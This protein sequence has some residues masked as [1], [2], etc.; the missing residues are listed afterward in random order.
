METKVF[1]SAA[2]DDPAGRACAQVDAREL[3]AAYVLLRDADE[4]LQVVT[5]AAKLLERNADAMLVLLREAQYLLGDGWNNET[6]VRA[7]MARRDAF[8]A[9]RLPA[10]R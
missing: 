5:A 6:E 3:D 1:M 4:T 9:V 10:K 8:M 7:W 2:S